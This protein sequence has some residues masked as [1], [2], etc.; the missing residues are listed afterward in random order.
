MNQCFYTGITKDIENRIASCDTCQTFQKAVPKELLISYSVPKRPW[1]RIGVDIFHFQGIDYLITVDYL[2]GFFE[3]DRLDSKR[4]QDVIYCLKIHMSRYGICDELISDNSPFQA[5][6]FKRFTELYEFK[7]ITS[8]PRYP[9][10][11]GKTELAVGLCKIFVMKAAHAHK[12]VY[13]ALLDF[14]NTP[15]HLGFSPAQI[16]FNRR[17]RTRL[18]MAH[19]LL[20][21]QF[22]HEAHSKLVENKHKQAIYYNRGAKERDS[23]KVGQTCRVKIDDR[24]K[25]PA[26][27]RVKFLKFIPFA[28]MM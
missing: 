2:S 25:L 5:A 14:R 6:E 8:S 21:S 7:H 26:G 11:N 19:D 4:I 18:P 10:S 27:A 17:T 15:G 12:D 1:E 16:M 28:D 13:L 9:I 22:S 23:F 3:I 24:I 20:E